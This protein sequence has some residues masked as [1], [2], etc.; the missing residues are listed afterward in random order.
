[1]PRCSD[2]VN[3]TLLAVSALRVEEPV[4]SQRGLWWSFGEPGIDGLDQGPGLFRDRGK[5]RL[6]VNSRPAVAPPACSVRSMIGRKSLTFSVS[7][8]PSEGFAPS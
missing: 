7:L 2:C 4:F 8:N 1:M 6:L 3:C 5:D